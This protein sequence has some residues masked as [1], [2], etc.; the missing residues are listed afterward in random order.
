[1]RE[2]GNECD[3][4]NCGGGPIF[5]LQSGYTVSPNLKD[6]TLKIS[7]CSTSNPSSINGGFYFTG[8]NEA[9]TNIPD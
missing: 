9:C 6:V 3:A 8:G 4:V 5:R 2:D 1:M 7:L